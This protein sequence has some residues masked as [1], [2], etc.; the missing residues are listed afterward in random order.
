[1]NQTNDPAGTPSESDRRQTALK[2]KSSR[3]IIPLAGV[4]LE[5]FQACPGSFP[6]Y[7]DSGGLSAIVNKFLRNNIAMPSPAH[8]MY[9]LRHSF[10][11]R[12]LAAGVDE[13]IR[14]DLMGHKLTRERYG[15]GASLAHLHEIVVS[16]AF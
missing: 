9:C 1:M 6:R 11:D 4:S 15:E 5:A 12:L 10:E 7:Q 14:R 2:T 3:R 16:V 8:T 13:R